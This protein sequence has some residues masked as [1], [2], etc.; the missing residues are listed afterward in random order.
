MVWSKTEL[1]R[2]FFLSSKKFLFQAF[3]AM[4][5]SSETMVPAENY[6]IFS[7]IFWIETVKCFLTLHKLSMCNRSICTNPF[8]LA[9]QRTIYILCNTENIEYIL[10][11]PCSL[12]L[13]RQ[14]YSSLVP[15]F[16][17][18]CPMFLSHFLQDIRIRW[19]V[20]CYN[21]WFCLYLYT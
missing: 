20:L 3:I 18:F 7:W 6:S 4:V 5:S 17:T 19:C 15:R 11:T 1:E 16:P 13:V 9:S 12:F 2:F 14:F 21:M 8:P 10:S